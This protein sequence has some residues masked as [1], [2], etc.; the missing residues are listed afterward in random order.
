L[1]NRNHVIFPD[2]LV[3]ELNRPKAGGILNRDE[4][5]FSWFYFSNKLF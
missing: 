4:G 5:L 3:R 1:P 2:W